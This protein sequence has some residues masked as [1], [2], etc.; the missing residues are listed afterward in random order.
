MGL[1]NKKESEVEKLFIEHFDVVG[2]TLAELRLSIFDYL[3]EKI[4]FKKHSFNVDQLEHKADILKHSVEL[5]LYEGAF[6]PIYR[7]DYLR[8][9]ECM[10]KVA[11]R[12]ED[13]ADF[14][15]LTR[16]KFPDWMKPE[17][18]NL[19]ELTITTFSS[20]RE[21]FEI[22][23]KDMSRVFGISEKVGNNEQEVDKLE[24]YATRKIFKSDLELAHKL[25]LKEFVVLIGKLSNRMEDVADQ[26]EIMAVKRRF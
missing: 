12:C 21:G 8:L 16:L 25:L 18:R 4:E 2:E 15:T 23:L 13:V 14:M 9:I 6:L 22:F 1:F 3:D 7:E 24:W 20:L 26:F 17:I 10:D 19:V 5:K 11:N